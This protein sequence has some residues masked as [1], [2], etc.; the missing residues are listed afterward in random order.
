M[1]KAA[2]HIKSHVM[3]MSLTDVSAFLCMIGYK[4]RYR[5]MIDWGAGPCYV[6]LLG[7]EYL[8]MIG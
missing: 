8:H 7:E 6:I 4:K 2:D 1:V 5:C 3:K